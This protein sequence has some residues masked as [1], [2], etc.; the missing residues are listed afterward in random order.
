L[1]DFFHPYLLEIIYSLYFIIIALTGKRH[2]EFSI[3]IKKPAVPTAG[4]VD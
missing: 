2:L 3:I 4:P 1:K